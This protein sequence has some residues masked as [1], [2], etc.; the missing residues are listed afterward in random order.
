MG[1]LEYY[2]LTVRERQGRYEES[3]STLLRAVEL[4]PN[5]HESIYQLGMA[6]AVLGKYERSE[7]ALKRA[8]ELM[9]D[10][11][12]YWY[13]LGLVQTVLMKNISARRSLESARALAGPPGSEIRKDIDAAL[14]RLAER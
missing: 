5:A 8:I 2:L 13:Q 12:V 10:N 14:N 4:S 3:E 7:K 9:P 6:F 11:P 1:R